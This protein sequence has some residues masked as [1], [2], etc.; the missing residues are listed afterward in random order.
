MLG[1]YSPVSAQENLGLLQIVS[2]N[3]LH[4]RHT[5]D[6]PV[7]GN[8]NT[9]HVPWDRGEAM[10]LSNFSPSGI[11]TAKAATLEVHSQSID[12]SPEYRKFHH[13][14]LKA[15]ASLCRWRHMCKIALPWCRLVNDRDRQFQVGM[16]QS[17]FL[18]WSSIGK[19]YRTTVDQVHHEEERAQLAKS[20]PISILS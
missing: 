18:P 16:L 3:P 8:F 13:L 12:Y 11:A 14:C 17:R 7:V 10:R 1:G 2:Y 20:P 4:T 19:S 5:G 6:E 9:G 15:Y